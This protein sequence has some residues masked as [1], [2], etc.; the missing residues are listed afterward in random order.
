MVCKNSDNKIEEKQKA[1]EESRNKVLSKKNKILIISVIAV[2][3]VVI[4]V[5][6]GLRLYGKNIKVGNITVE[7]PMINLEITDEWLTNK[8]KENGFDQFEYVNVKIINI[9]DIDYNN[10]DKLI[11]AEVT[12]KNNGT[13]ESKVG[14]ELANKKEDIVEG[15]TINN[16][17]IWI[18]PSLKNSNKNKSEEVLDTCAKYIQA[19]GA[20]IFNDRENEMFGELTKEISKIIGIKKARECVDNEF[21]KLSNAD[22]DCILLFEKESA[23]IK[24]IAFYEEKLQFNPK[25]SISEQMY[26]YF[27]SSYKYKDTIATYKLIYGEPYVM[28]GQYVIADSSQNVVGTY[29]SLE[30]VK[31]QYNVEEYTD[32][33]QIEENTNNEPDATVNNAD[34]KENTED[35]K[36][37][38]NTNNT[39]TSEDIVQESNDSVSEE[40]NEENNVNEELKEVPQLVGLNLRE[41]EKKLSGIYITDKIY[42]YTSSE[43]KDETIAEQSVA[44]GTKGKDITLTVKIYEYI[45]DVKLEMPFEITYDSFDRSKYNSVVVKFNDKIVYSGYPDDTIMSRNPFPVTD[46]KLSSVVDNTIKAEIYLDNKLIKTKA[47]QVKSFE[48]V[49]LN[50]NNR[51]EMNKLTMDISEELKNK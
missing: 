1:C 39:S 47:F 35:E 23:R 14:I 31:N 41:A 33:I 17:L 11:L 24:Y 43:E 38:V 19:Y 6:I 25:W 2:I 51:L 49:E 26:K 32:D 9:T 37:E 4:A 10:F 29:R 21:R 40:Y 13:T 50:D 42:V 8:F 30:F 46:F 48:G 27:L 34:L 15:V 18:L 36:E 16:N 44:A 3:I 12:V 5:L 45:P 20:E 22:S 28:V 7:N